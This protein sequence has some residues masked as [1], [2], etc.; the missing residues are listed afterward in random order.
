VIKERTEDRRIE[1]RGYLETH[2]HS[3]M[4]DVRRLN[5]SYYNEEAAPNMSNQNLNIETKVLKL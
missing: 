2:L 1:G 4:R 3:C 5:A